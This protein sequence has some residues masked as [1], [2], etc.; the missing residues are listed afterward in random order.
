MLHSLGK[1]EANLMLLGARE[2]VSD[3]V[4][5]RMSDCAYR[6]ANVEEFVRL[7]RFHKVYPLV[8]QSLRQID[9]HANPAFV[10]SAIQRLRGRPFRRWP[11]QRTAMQHVIE[12]VREVLN[13]ADRPYAFM[14]GVPYAEQC[15]LHPAL[16]VSADIDILVREPDCDAVFPA[17]Y[18]AGL[19]LYGNPTLWE[20]R[21]AYSGQA[22][23]LCTSSRVAVD[24]AWKLMGNGG[25]RRVEADTDRVWE[26]AKPASGGEYRL[27]NEDTAVNMIRHV[28]VGHDFEHG[29][30]QS[31]VDMAALMR[32][33]GEE[34][35][36]DFVCA[37]T[38]R[39]ECLRATHFFAH[40]FDE[41]YRDESMPALSER[42]SNTRDC[43]SR[44]ECRRFARTI[45]A[46]LVRRKLNAQTNTEFVNGS[47][48]IAAKLW[49]LDRLRRLCSILLMIPCA[50]EHEVTL[51]TFT[52]RSQSHVWRRIRF[53]GEVIVPGTPG[54]LLGSAAR[55][56]HE[57]LRGIER[58]MR[59]PLRVFRRRA[60]ACEESRS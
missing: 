59:L 25:H 28:A 8:L 4:I 5:E 30:M 15:Y 2:V 57:A 27:S 56:W 31:C 17:L 58:A 14:R 29:F 55:L 21:A 22:E 43:T 7:C 45:Q 33:H 32:I 53:I 10:E 42:L 50:T 3:D 24:V 48:S 34:M 49:C 52:S 46:P 13:A 1:P 41:Y 60:E 37:E 11:R 38:K 54:A 18:E 20:A 19:R 6:C 51:L 16:R 36:W 39:Q 35:D 9:A 26:R 12:Q 47:L 44:H 23:L 40:F